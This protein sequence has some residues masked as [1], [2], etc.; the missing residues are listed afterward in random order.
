[1]P[2]AFLTPEKAKSC[3]T[4]QPGIR[5]KVP[6]SCVLRRATCRVRGG[7]ILAASSPRESGRSSPPSRS[8][9]T[10]RQGL[11]PP[12]PRE[13][14]ARNSRCALATIP[15]LLGPPGGLRRI[16]IRL[17]RGQPLASRNPNPSCV[18]NPGAD[19]AAQSRGSTAREAPSR[20]EASEGGRPGA[21]RRAR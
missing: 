11:T 17:R 10:S 16:G 21:Q 12:Y 8:A 4:G 7:A 6:Q 13:P 14:K 3:A 19:D 2:G 5:F 18:S 15:P 1:M 20:S 9:R